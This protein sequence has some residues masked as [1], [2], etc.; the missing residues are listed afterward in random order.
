MSAKVS[1]NDV[2]S[3]PELQLA[4]TWRVDDESARF[5]NHELA[6][7][8]RMP[9][10]RVP[11]ADFAGGEELAFDEP[12]DDRRLP[13]ARGSQQRDGPAQREK[14]HQPRDAGRGFGADGM[15]GHV[16]GGG[17]G[18][19]DPR[20]NVVSQIGLVQHDDRLGAAPARDDEVPLDRP[21]VDRFVQAEHDEDGIH[22]GGNDLFGGLPA[23]GAA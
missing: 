5:A 22:V 10:T 17:G 11:F 15:N 23:G 19:G 1:P 18:L 9:A 12:V 13:R 4:Q 20:A 14:R 21:H 6:V 8:A 2:A 3:V 16:A 7:H